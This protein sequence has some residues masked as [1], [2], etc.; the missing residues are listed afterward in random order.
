MVTANNTG[1]ATPTLVLLVVNAA[2]AAVNPT[3]GDKIY[4]N[5][6]LQSYNAN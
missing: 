5:L 3:T 1:A 4:F 2:G 6:E